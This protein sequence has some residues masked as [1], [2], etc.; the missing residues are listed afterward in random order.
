M[1][2]D[3]TRFAT[4]AD[5]TLRRIIEAIDAAEAGE[6]EADLREGVLTI[7]LES[8]GQYIVNKH[9]PN[10]EIWVSSPRS[11]AWHFAYDE[12][13]RTWVDTRGSGELPMTLNK[14]LG[15]ELGEVAHIELSLP[16]DK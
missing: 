5:E 8:G 13:K 11:G 7:E 14:L 1:A 10:R 9:A 6:L 12:A 3:E 16:G 4:I 2:L 15:G